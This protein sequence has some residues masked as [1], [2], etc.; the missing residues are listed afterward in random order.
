MENAASIFR[1]YTFLEPSSRGDEIVS[2]S[3]TSITIYKLHR[4]TPGAMT[5]QSY[6][7]GKTGM[8]QDTLGAL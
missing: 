3:E 4:H 8:P 6:K 5:P 7:I 1:V 2:S